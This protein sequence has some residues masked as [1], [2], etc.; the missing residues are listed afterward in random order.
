MRFHTGSSKVLE[1]RKTKQVFDALLAEVVV[2]AEDALLGEHG[3]QRGVQ[4]DGAGEVAT[5]RLL[6]DDAATLVEP[7]RRERLG[8]GREHRRRDRHVEDG[9]LALVPVERA[10]AATP[11]SCG[12]RSR[13]G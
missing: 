4:L 6:D 5:E 1:N 13:P 7:D 2:D 12:R 3:V 10:R 11:T 8:N 9:Y